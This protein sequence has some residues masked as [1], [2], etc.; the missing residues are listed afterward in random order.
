MEEKS[1]NLVFHYSLKVKDIREVEK[2]LEYAEKLQKEHS[3]HCTLNVKVESY[4]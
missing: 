2:Y 3:Y 4:S 1:V